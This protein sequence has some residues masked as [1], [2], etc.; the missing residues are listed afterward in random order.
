MLGSLGHMLGVVALGKQA[1][2]YRRMQ[3]LNATVHHLGE[4]GYLV[5]RGYG[6]TCLCDNASRATR[7]DDLRPEFLGQ[8]AR[9]LDHARL[10]RY[11]HKNTLYLWI[12]H[13][14]PPFQFAWFLYLFFAIS[15]HTNV[16]A[17]LGFRK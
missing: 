9:E 6:N 8:C 5:D 12:C 3:G 11:R 10:V 7:R 16:L 1:A 17:C 15:Q 4:L 13:L 14:V 2:M